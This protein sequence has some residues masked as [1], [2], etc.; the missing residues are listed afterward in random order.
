[1]PAAKLPL[2]D[3]APRRIGLIKPSALGDII[4]SLPVLTALR[5]RYPAAH[6]T[7]IVNR[8]YEPLLNGH[9][10]LNATLAFDRT[11]SRFEPM[12]AV[13]RYT[14]FL[15][16]L[17]QRRFDLVLDLQGLLRS[18]IMCRA[19]GAP[20]RV[21]LSTARE[22][23]TWF[24]TDVVPV[25]DFNALHAVERYWL[26]AQA[27]GAGAGP[28]QFRLPLSESARVW[29]ESALHDCPPPWLMFGVGSRWMTK[30][31][32][33]EH[34]AALAQRAQRHFGGTVVFLGG[35]DETAL[36]R[37]TAAH[38]SGP[39][40]DLTGRTTLPQLAAVLQR[41]DVMVANDTGPLHLAAALGRPVV[42][43]Y[44]CT[45]VLLNGPYGAEEGAVESGVWCQGS[46]LKRCR[47]LE[48]M[49]ELTPERLWPVL[50][51]VLREWENKRRI[52]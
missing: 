25:S 15:S 33:P 29:A 9:P 21:G 26:I 14:R 3:Y 30:R 39:S 23:A 45:R 16:E 5:Q 11:T 18:G 52:A 36:A 2:C 13:F 10:D 7:W 8:T 17:R 28:K 34:F 19:S 38:L 24:Y 6:I 37:A 22:G 27:L 12:Q 35:P 51:G 49:T 43:P 20:R 41:A 46:Y 40:R 4:H 42:A 1:M 32:P 47:R 48:C 44:T 50:Q 31:W